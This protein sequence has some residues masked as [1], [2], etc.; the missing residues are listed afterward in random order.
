MHTIGR[1]IEVGDDVAVHDASGL[2]V[3]PGGIDVHTHIDWEF[4][5]A[6][7][8]ERMPPPLRAMSS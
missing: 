2:L 8:V 4:G 5:V 3:V 7:T 1:D 6:R